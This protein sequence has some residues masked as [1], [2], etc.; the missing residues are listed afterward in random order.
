[1]HAY[2]HACIG[3]PTYHVYSYTHRLLHIIIPPRSTPLLPSPLPIPC[4]T[5][6]PSTPPPVPATISISTPT[7]LPFLIALVISASTRD[8]SITFVEPV[9]ARPPTFPAIILTGSIA[10][11]AIARIVPFTRRGARVVAFATVASGFGGRGGFGWG[12]SS[13]RRCRRIRSGGGGRWGFAGARDVS[14]DAI[15]TS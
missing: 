11:V 12:C 9:P 4:A 5:P 14:V 13:R 7:S 10:P 15:R 8:I 2:T 6:T 1:M 3:N